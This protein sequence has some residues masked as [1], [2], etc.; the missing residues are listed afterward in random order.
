[1]AQAILLIFTMVGS[2]LLLAIVAR[3]VIVITG[4]INHFG[5]GKDCYLAMIGWGVRAIDKET[6]ILPPG[7]AELNS[8]L[9]A[10]REGLIS[11]DR[12]VVVATESQE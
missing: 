4:L 2:T 12:H 8:Q 7:I 9:R 10:I 5:A 6:A 1:M 11:I 3:Y